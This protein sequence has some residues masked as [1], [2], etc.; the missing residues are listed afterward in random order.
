MQEK[1]S[2]I[3][4]LKKQGQMMG[5]K[6][7]KHKRQLEQIQVNNLVVLLRAFATNRKIE[8]CSPQPESN[9]TLYVD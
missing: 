3:G 4:D 1:Q 5:K 7:N 6:K 9:E 2:H 8:K